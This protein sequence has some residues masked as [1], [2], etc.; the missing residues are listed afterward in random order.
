MPSGQQIEFFRKVDPAFSAIY[1][2]LPYG[3]KGLFLFIYNDIFNNWDGPKKKF[4]TIQGR[5]SAMPIVVTD[6]LPFA[7]QM[8]Y[9][10]KPGD[11]FK[12][13]Y[14]LKR[15]CD[16]HINQTLWRRSGWIQQTND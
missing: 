4:N 5:L 3:D 11:E 14:E 7:F 2:N 16:N 9:N 8:K 6:L 12:S 1:D 10:L 13:G 15:Y